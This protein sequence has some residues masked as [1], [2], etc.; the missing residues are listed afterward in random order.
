MSNKTIL[1][2]IE[3]INQIIN[4]EEIDEY[5]KNTIISIKNDTFKNNI[6]DIEKNKIVNSIYLKKKSKIG[7][8]IETMIWQYYRHRGKLDVNK[9]IKQYG[10]DNLVINYSIKPSQKISNTIE[11]E[12]IKL[13]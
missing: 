3:Y 13:S 8:H 10:R 6:I 5:T 9:I 1:N 11:S 12:S 2:N 4:L 7:R